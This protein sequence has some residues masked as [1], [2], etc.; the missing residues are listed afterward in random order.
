MAVSDAAIAMADRHINEVRLRIAQHR[1]LISKMDARGQST[2][3]A[4]QIL[5]TFLSVL[6]GMVEHRARMAR[7][8]ERAQEKGGT[9]SRGNKEEVRRSP[10]CRLIGFRCTGYTA[11]ALK[12]PLDAN[13]RC[14]E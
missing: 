8:I 3:L 11:G 4:N 6:D 7:G 13:R 14:V 12:R 1:E 5:T 2:E 9:P 10:E